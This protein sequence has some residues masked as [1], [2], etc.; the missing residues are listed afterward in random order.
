MDQRRQAW[1]DERRAAVRAA[2]DAEARTYDEDADYPTPLQPVFVRRLV[3]TCPPNGRVLDAPCGTGRYFALVTEAGRRVVGIDQSAG[4]LVRARARGLA[5]AIGQVGLQEMTF[6]RAFD[7][8]MTVDAMEN[9]PP[10]DWLFV[11]GNLRRAIRP[12]GHI[13]ITVEEIDDAEIEAAFVDAHARG[14][15]AVRGEVIEGDTA[16]YHY[17]PERARVMGWLEAEYLQ[18]VDEAHDRQDGWSYRHL[19]LRS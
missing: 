4:M 19:L 6:D 16:G 18:V 14:W 10:E 9:I 13:Y 11:L 17:Y 2:Y 3:G 7:A 1:L 5:E 8:A 12:G 15:P